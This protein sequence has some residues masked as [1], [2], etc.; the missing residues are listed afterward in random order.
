MSKRV[1]EGDVSS[2]HIFDRTVIVNLALKTLEDPALNHAVAVDCHI[3]GGKT[4]GKSSVR[5]RRS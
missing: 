1:E 2:T 4:P 5:L 3:V